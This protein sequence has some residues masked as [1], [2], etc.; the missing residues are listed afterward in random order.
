MFRAFALQHATHTFKIFS[1]ISVWYLGSGGMLFGQEVSI[2]VSY[3]TVFAENIVAVRYAMENW[4]GEM[5]QPE[6]GDFEVVGGPQISSSMSISGGK[7]TSSKTVIMFLKPPAV[8]GEYI[9][10][11]I[12]FRGE[13]KK[14]ET[15]EKSIIV[16]ANPENLRQ[17]PVFDRPPPKTF[18]RQYKRSEPPRGKRQ[19][20]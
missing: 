17:E 6:F 13:G 4:Q 1:I 12:T 11:P 18:D 19:R 9:L 10:P 16:V 8:P 2:D 14:Y 3:D 7:K 5:D 15:K 20:F